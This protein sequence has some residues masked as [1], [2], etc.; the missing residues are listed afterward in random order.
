MRSDLSTTE[1]AQIATSAT[2]AFGAPRLASGFNSSL[3][4]PPPADLPSPDECP[5]FFPEGRAPSS[6]RPVFTHNFE[7]RLAKGAL[8]TSS[9]PLSDADLFIWVRHLG[10]NETTGGVEGEGVVVVVVVDVVNVVSTC[11]ANISPRYLSSF[12]VIQLVRSG[13]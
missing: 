9:A 8:N 12:I 6:F 7:A 2:F 4:P 5:S 1:D 13:N 11:V 10:G 3:V